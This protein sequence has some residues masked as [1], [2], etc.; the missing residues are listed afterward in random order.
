MSNQT[1]VS[2]QTLSPNLCFLW[3]DKLHYLSLNGMCIWRPALAAFLLASPIA[4]AASAAAA[5]AD[6][7]RV[8]LVCEGE[9]P[10]CEFGFT[11]P[12]LKWAARASTS[13]I[14]AFKFPSTMSEKG[15]IIFKI[16]KVKLEV[17][18]LTQRDSNP[19][20]LTLT[21]WKNHI[22]KIL[23]CLFL[24]LHKIILKLN[25]HNNLVQPTCWPN[26]S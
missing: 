3:D 5:A 22:I 12:G 21:I 19:A 7:L 1:L 13:R 20:F 15:K 4:A 8:S 16:L 2:N 11:L 14:V 10:W 9:P 25:W 26:D 23:M 24:K 6:G 17:I 18:A